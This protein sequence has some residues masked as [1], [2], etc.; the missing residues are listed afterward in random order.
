MK[1]FQIGKHLVRLS[2]SNGRWAV[3]VDDSALAKWYMT[4]ADAWTAGVHEVDR[5]DG[6]AP[7]R[8]HRAG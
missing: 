1:C 6:L 5:L 2:D 7:M 8:A 3:T 4:M